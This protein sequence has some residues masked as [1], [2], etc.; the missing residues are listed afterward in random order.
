MPYLS[1]VTLTKTEQETLLRVSSELAPSSHLYIQYKVTCPHPSGH[2]S[3]HQ[4]RACNC[5]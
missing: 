2:D 3:V 1:P 5:P 4:L